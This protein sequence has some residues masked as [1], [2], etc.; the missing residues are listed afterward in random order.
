MAG[1]SNLAQGTW[2]QATAMI[3]TTLATWTGADAVSAGDIR[4]KL[5][6]IG[7]DCPLH[8]DAAA[9]SDHGYR[10][11]VSPVSM[12][13][14]WAMPPY[15]VPGLPPMGAEPMST[16]IPATTVPG[17]GDTMIATRI[18]TEH[19]APVYPGDRISGT[20]VLRSVTPKNTRVGPGAFLVVE[21]TYSNQ[22]GE[23]VSIETATLLR[24]QQ[25]EDSP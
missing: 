25:N 12:V 2:A 4:R 21:T 13:R 7:F 18:R 24:Y 9:A 1:V 3:G 5:E 22:R 19:L 10:T 11:I 15:W 6:V 17:E 8:D 20:A 23:I 16:P 14:V